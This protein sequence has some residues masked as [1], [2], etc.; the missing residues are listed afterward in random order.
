MNSGVV[1]IANSGSMNQNFFGSPNS[2]SDNDTYRKLYK[3]KRQ[4][5][6]EMGE[7]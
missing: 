5:P 3:V 6:N 2:Q 7:N 1:N 4:K